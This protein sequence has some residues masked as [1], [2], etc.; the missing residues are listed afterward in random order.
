MTN[1]RYRLTADAVRLLFRSDG[2]VLC[3]RRAA[4]SD[5]APRQLAVL[6]GHLE[7]GESLDQAAHGEARVEAGVDVDPRHQEFC[8]L[9]HDNDPPRRPPPVPGRLRRCLML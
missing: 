6:G 5:P 4:G 3:V 2:R 1:D 8:G 9:V 7:E